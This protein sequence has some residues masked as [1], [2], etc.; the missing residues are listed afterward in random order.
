MSKKILGLEFLRGLCALLV[1]VYHCLLF[2]HLAVLPTWGLYG[3]YIFFVI[4]GAV[5]FQNYHSTLT[6]TVE[7][8]DQISVAKFMLKRFARIAPLVWACMLGPAVLRNSWIPD[9]YFLN[10]TLLFGL[11]SPGATSYLTGGWT[12]GIEFALYALFPVLLAFTRSWRSTALTLIT[13]LL[14]RAAFLSFVLKSGSL[15]QTWPINT[16]PAAFLVFFFGGMAIA[17]L[18]PQLSFP[19]AAMLAVALIAALP[20]VLFPGAGYSAVLL[21]LHGVLLTLASLVVVAGF[22]WSPRARIPAAVFGFFGDISYGL[23]LLHPIVWAGLVHYVPALPPK[24]RIVATLAISI[25]AAKILL[26]W[27]ERPVRAWIV[28]VAYPTRVERPLAISGE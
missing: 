12:L 13:F 28:R 25:V 11:G 14:L 15:A 9:Q 27:Y 24:A 6:L 21:G 16:Q 7:R 10:L 26:R 19:R 18:A 3:V 1:A 8:P 5:L 22:F 4:S 23:Y 17:K 2:T 20:I